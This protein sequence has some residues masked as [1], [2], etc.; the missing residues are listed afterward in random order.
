[1]LIE[2]VLV[3]LKF[4]KTQVP[5]IGEVWVPGLVLTLTCFTQIQLIQLTCF[6]LDDNFC[7]NLPCTQLPDIGKQAQSSKQVKFGL[8]LKRILDLGTEI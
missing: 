3:A 4:F 6:S 5:I 7:R 8:Q 2:N 1:M